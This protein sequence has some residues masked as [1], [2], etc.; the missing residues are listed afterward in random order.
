[1]WSTSRK[2]KATERLAARYVVWAA[3]EF[4]YPRESA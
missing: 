2:H 4:G 3:G 1:M